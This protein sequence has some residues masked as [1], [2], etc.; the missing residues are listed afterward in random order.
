MRQL[1]WMLLGLAVMLTAGCGFHLRGTASLPQSIDTLFIQGIDLLDSRGS[2]LKEGLENNG[3]KVASK[4]K[5]GQAVMTI[6]DNI[7][8]RRVLSVGSD[9]KVS[10]YELYGALRFTV[11]DGDG[12]S[13]L[14]A[15]V[16]EARRDYQF[17]QEQVLSADEE[18]ILLR[19][20][21]DQ[22]LVQAVLRRLSALK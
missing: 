2:A 14:A 4:Y 12:K 21:I 22:Q 13:L 15:Q 6:V 10:E 7:Q 3:V 8:E 19:E 11:S 20:Q 18:E 17:D 5:A 9:A 1:G 16:V